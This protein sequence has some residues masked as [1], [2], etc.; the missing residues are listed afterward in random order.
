MLNVCHYKWKESGELAFR[1]ILKELLVHACLCDHSHVIFS[2]K[3][4][5]NNILKF[6]R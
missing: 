5:E 1:G 3:N 2:K 6:I 4:Y